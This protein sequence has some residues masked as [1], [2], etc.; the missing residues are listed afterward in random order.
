[1]AFLGLIDTMFDFTR[2]IAGETKEA[3]VQRHVQALKRQAIGPYLMRRIRKTAAHYVTQ[4]GVMT[5]F[6]PNY[7]RMRFGPPIPYTR[8]LDVYSYVYSSATWRYTLHPYSGPITMFA[9]IGRE[10]YQRARWSRVAKGQLTVHEMPG[11][12]FDM[13]E[14]PHSTVLAAK[15]DECL[16]RIGA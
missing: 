1:M 10:E 2:E 9:A 5:R 8:R 11:A 3:R 16:E 14:P 4:T 6:L 7:L 13:V 12:H 15:F